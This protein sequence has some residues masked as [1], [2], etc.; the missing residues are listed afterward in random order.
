MQSRTIIPQLGSWNIKTIILLWKNKT[1]ENSWNIWDF[2]HS[3]HPSLPCAPISFQKRL[4]SLLESSLSFLR[5]SK[6]SATGKK[7]RG[8]LRRVPIDQTLYNVVQ[9]SWELQTP[10]P[11]MTR[12]QITIRTSLTAFKEVG[13]IFTGEKKMEGFWQLRRLRNKVV[14]K[15]GERIEGGDSR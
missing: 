7:R 11:A 15:N 14:E 6:I 2:V 1:Y 4:K 5:L 10:L 3:R 9:W 8:A 12:Y 13:F